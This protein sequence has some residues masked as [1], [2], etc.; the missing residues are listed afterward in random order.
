ME[1]GQAIGAVV[2]MGGT[3]RVGGDVQTAADT[4]EGVR[5]VAVAAVEDILATLWTAGP[6]RGVLPS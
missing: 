2:A 3:R 5:P 4:P 6:A 1:T